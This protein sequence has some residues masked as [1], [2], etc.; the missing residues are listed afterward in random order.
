MVMEAAKG[1]HTHVVQLLIDFPNSVLVPPSG[2]QMTCSAA[3]E[4]TTP[5]PPSQSVSPAIDETMMINPADVAAVGGMMK[6]Q[7]SCPL[8]V[9][10]D[11]SEEDE[12]DEEGTS[13]EDDEAV[14]L[15]EDDVA[16]EG[17]EEEMAA[18]DNKP[19]KSSLSDRAE[20][21][22]RERNRRNLIVHPRSAPKPR[23][24]FDDYMNR[25]AAANTAADRMSTTDEASAAM[26]SFALPGELHPTQLESG[27][28]GE[29]TWIASPA[30]RRSKFSSVRWHSQSGKCSKCF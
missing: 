8:T 30:Q 17:D 11:T 21:Y 19:A 18:E 22:K 27:Q 3:T 29:A 28:G 16:D 13:A 4:T 14:D 6:N 1:G 26:K 25:T 15:P 2:T 12:D 24:S 10:T 7:Y 23:G 9:E 20:K 5:S